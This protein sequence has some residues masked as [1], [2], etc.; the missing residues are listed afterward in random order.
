MSVRANSMPGF[1][2]AQLRRTRAVC[3]GALLLGCI[4]LT[5]PAIGTEPQNDV[6]EIA[7]S[8]KLS[9]FDG[10]VALLEQVRPTRSQLTD[11]ERHHFD[12]LDGWRLV[13]LGDYTSA[14][15]I[16]AMVR[17]NEV[18]PVLAF[19]AHASTVNALTLARRYR[20]SFTELDQMLVELPSIHDA[21]ALEQALGIA[22]ML[23]NQVGQHALAIDYATK[24]GAL[25]ES[26]WTQCA[27]AQLRG[28]ALLKSGH[29]EEQ[30]KA[31][32]VQAQRCS[33]D[34]Q[35]VFAN[36]IRV[37]VGRALIDSGQLDDA[38]RLLEDNRGEAQRTRYPRLSS[39]FDALLARIHLLLG[40]PVRAREYGISAITGAR[41][42]EYTEPLVEA[43][44]ILYQIAKESGDFAAALE[45]HEKYAT[46]DKGYLD[47]VSAKQLAY[48]MVRHQAVADKLQIEALNRQNEVLKLQQD[49]S[50]QEV[51][52][53]R[54]SIALLVTVVASIAFF[55][56]RVKRSQLHFKK[57][58]QHDHLT[59]VASRAHFIQ[60]AELALESCRRAAQPACMLILDLDHFKV[61][62]DS[63]GHAAGDTVLRRS[64]EACRP[65][66]R[67]GDVFGR[68]GGEEFGVLL[69]ACAIE[70]ARMIADDLRRAVLS[71][72]GRDLGMAGPV[73]ASFGVST[74]AVSGYTFRDL[75]ANADAALYEAKRA[76]RN[77]VEVFWRAA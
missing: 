44:R 1:F 45:F 43:Y 36:L 27:A 33:N 46:A 47:D 50:S 20:E 28:E 67:K 77:R 15:R 6:L 72:D 37:Y 58:A 2:S 55:A 8:I 5:G 16:L 41:E 17:A 10:F 14:I 54:L 18:S 57:L 32:G 42:N 68:L 69:P 71:V 11:A 29:G 12:Y 76:G 60:L 7:D 31:L 38:R 9:D 21:A 30:L 59:G 56:F 75:I 3:A 35:Y 40:D 51:D 74:T 53:S 66:L 19:R 4:L 13:Y 23:H 26:S 22:A 49:L 61:V 24:L 64:V 52:N 73:S 70:E 25:G 62:N 34:K 39:D 65:R 48:E 63:H